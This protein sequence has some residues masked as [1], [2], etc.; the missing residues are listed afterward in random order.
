MKPRRQEKIREIV[1]KNVIETQE[2]LTEFLRREHIK[3]TQATVSR[4]IK[5]LMLVKKPMG[6]GRS[7]YALPESGSVRGEI[8]WKIF[9]ATRSRAL[10]PAAILL[11]CGRF[12]AWRT[13]WLLR[14]MGR[15]SRISSARL[16]ET[17]R[18]LSPS[19]RERL[20]PP[21][22]NVCGRS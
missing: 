17:I 2:E 12:R 3:V 6:G 13:P 11:S 1:E 7:R 5:E 8:A 14:S 21:S 22:Q 9:S 20:R 19:D 10:T 4:D 18:F 15:S 16:P